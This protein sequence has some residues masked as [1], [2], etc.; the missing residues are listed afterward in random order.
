MKRI[1]GLKFSRVGFLE[2]DLV[3]ILGVRVLGC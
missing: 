2:M 1:N 3:W